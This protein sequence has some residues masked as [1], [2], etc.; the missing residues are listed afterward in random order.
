M[1][2]EMQS[3]TDNNTWDLIYL[4]PGYRAIGLMWVYK[5]KCNENGDIVRHKAR[6]VAKGYV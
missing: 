4:P 5:V 1:I 6:L 3:I 2:E